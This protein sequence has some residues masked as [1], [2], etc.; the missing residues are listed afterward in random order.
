M[1]QRSGRDEMLKQVEKALK[2]RDQIGS[3]ADPKSYIKDVFP[4]RW[5]IYND[6]QT[7]PDD[8]PALVYFGGFANNLLLGMGGSSCHV[9]GHSGATGTWSR[10]STPTLTRWLLSGLHS[11]KAPKDSYCVN[12]REEENEVFRA[13]AVA[14]YYLR[15][16]TQKVEF[17]AKTIAIGEVRGMES[18]INVEKAKAIL[19]TPL[20]VAQYDI[21]EVHRINEVPVWGLTERDWQVERRNKSKSRRK[22]ER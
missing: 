10:S 14:Q 2:E 3:L 13:M 8:E 19:A 18:F 4:V 9:E 20:Y 7:R 5:G 6:C 15:P 1:E 16:P 12:I 17:L 21:N 22:R 11:G